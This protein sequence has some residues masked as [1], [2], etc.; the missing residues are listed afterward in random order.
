M[1]SMAS[2]KKHIL[3][4]LEAKSAGGRVDNELHDTGVELAQLLLANK[5]PN[6]SWTV[7]TRNIEGI[8]VQGYLGDTLDVACEVTTHNFLLGKARQNILED[9]ERLHDSGAQNRFLAL[10]HAEVLVQ[11]RKMRSKKLLQGVWAIDLPTGHFD[12]LGA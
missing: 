7:A 2:L 12:S 8:D 11:L 5:F 9:L 3:Q 1:T 6:R 4:L 10:V